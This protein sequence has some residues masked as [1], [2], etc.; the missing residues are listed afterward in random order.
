MRD[1]HDKLLAGLSER[2]AE[3]RD[4]VISARKMGSP[5]RPGADAPLIHTL[6][7]L[8]PTGKV[9][10][11]LRVGPRRWGSPHMVMWDAIALVVNFAIASRGSGEL[12][13]VVP[14][15][16]QADDPASP[17]FRARDVSFDGDRVRHWIRE[18]AVQRGGGGTV[19]SAKAYYELLWLRRF[20]DFTQSANDVVEALGK[21][22]RAEG[23]QVGV[24]RD[25]ST[26]SKWTTGA[27]EPGGW[28]L[29]RPFL[30]FL[31][32]RRDMLYSKARIEFLADLV[33]RPEQGVADIRPALEKLGWGPDTAQL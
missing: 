33:R 25:R 8:E 15:D 29:G 32:E 22:R 30:Q 28:R 13:C 17:H 27:A 6:P 31:L 21:R 2:A 20:D 9:G 5:R 4:H 18:H 19:E 24:V 16:S 11:R 12:L 23:K 14:S 3:M 1:T 7:L 26:I 10:C